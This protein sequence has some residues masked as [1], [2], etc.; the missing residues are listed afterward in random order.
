MKKKTTCKF[1]K[2]DIAEFYPS[3]SAE[4]LEKSINFVRSIIKEEDKTI[5]IIKCARK[6]LL[7]HNGNTQVKKKE[8]PYLG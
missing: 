6:S 3:I 2:F 5:N 8:I 4:L 7:F 1:I